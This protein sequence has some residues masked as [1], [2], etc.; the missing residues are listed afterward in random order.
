MNLPKCQLSAWALEDMKPDSLGTDWIDSPPL[1][2]SKIQGVEKDKHVEYENDKNK[3]RKLF[4]LNLKKK[5]NTK[6][7]NSLS[8]YQKEMK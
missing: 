8:E 5:K 6:E 3:G 7:K 1:I 4:D 2:N